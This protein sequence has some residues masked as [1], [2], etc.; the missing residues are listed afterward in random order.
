MTRNT[1]CD[2]VLTMSDIQITKLPK[3]GWYRATRNSISADAKTKKKAV[4]ELLETE[5]FIRISQ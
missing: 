2:I 1:I 4:K 5:M 3:K